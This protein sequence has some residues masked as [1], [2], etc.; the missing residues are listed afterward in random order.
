MPSQVCLTHTIE[1]WTDLMAYVRNRS[2]E[3]QTA[4]P[5]VADFIP[6]AF[7][8]RRPTGAV[9]STSVR[10]DDAMRVAS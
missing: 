4:E 5:P 3:S 9:R 10:R 7:G 2:A 1:F 6:T 8:A